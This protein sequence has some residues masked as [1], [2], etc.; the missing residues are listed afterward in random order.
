MNDDYQMTETVRM[1]RNGTDF[2]AEVAFSITGEYRPAS[3]DDPA[4]YP[5]VEVFSARRVNAKTGKVGAE[6]TLTQEER[7]R[8]RGV[9]LSKTNQRNRDAATD[10]AVSCYESRHEMD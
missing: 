5:E 3:W 8:L 9:V 7:E 6:I 1:V 10:Y 4:E 2:E